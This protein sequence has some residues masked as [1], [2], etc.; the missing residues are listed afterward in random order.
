M[1]TT[2]QQCAQDGE[3]HT[4][5]RS[6]TSAGCI[7]PCTTSRFDTAQQPLRDSSTNKVRVRKRERT[8]HLPL[9]HSS[10][11]NM[12]REARI[13]QGFS[14]TATSPLQ[15]KQHG[16]P[17]NP[18]LNKHQ[19]ANPY[20]YRAAQNHTGRGKAPQPISPQLSHPSPSQTL[21]CT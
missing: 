18:L 12:H 9:P 16:T 3:S 17:H 15:C 8:T 13:W 14:P 7:T 6:K 11:N 4:S 5:G 1:G 10:W 21:S 19:P 2:S 20:P